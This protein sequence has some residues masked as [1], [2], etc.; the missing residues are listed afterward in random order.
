MVT[1]CPS[2]EPNRNPLD[3]VCCQYVMSYLLM[4]L[5][6]NPRPT[7]RLV[8]ER[9]EVIRAVAYAMGSTRVVGSNVPLL[10]MMLDRIDLIL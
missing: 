3:V 2:I 10:R 7:H 1:Q 4:L 5:P 6:L 8:W 9:K